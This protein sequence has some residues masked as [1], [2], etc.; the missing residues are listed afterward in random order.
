MIRAASLLVATIAC[1]PCGNTVLSE[2][3]APTGGR[4]AI[5]FI[6]NCGA[7][8]AFSTQVSIL[9]GDHRL[10]NEAG[11]VL[12]A[13]LAGND[14]LVAVAWKSG[15]SLDVSY[16]ASAEVFKRVTAHDGVSV[17]YRPT[18]ER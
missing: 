11:N 16:P 4:R 15:T 6:R 13:K 14:S 8:T 10:E 12:V 18:S 17:S 9:P 5:V 2:V 3:D 7:T 1:N